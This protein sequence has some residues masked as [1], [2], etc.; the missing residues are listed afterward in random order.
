MSCVIKDQ[1]IGQVEKV[2][3]RGNSMGEAEALKSSGLGL[4]L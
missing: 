1:A 3:G 2:G 4:G